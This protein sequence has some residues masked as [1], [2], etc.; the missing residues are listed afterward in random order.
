MSKCDLKEP[1]MST[2]YEK[3][4]LYKHSLIWD[5]ILSMIYSFKDNNESKIVIRVLL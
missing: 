3:L 5:L 2:L 4:S 1:Y